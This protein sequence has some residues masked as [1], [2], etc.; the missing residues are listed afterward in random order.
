[1]TK[2][3]L[4]GGFMLNILIKPASS[5]CNMRCKYCFY[6]DV[7][8]NRESASF[9]IMSEAV[10]DAFLKNLFSYAKA[11]ISFTFQGGEPT[12]AGV[13]YFRAFHSLVEKYNTRGLPVAFSLQTNG[14]GLSEELV[15]VFAKYRY[16]L[17]V[18]LDGDGE[19]HDSLR[20][21]SDGA[22]T[23][24]KINES[25]KLLDKYKVEYNILTVITEQVASRGADVY[26]ILRERGF[27]FLQFIPF[28]PDFFGAGECESYTLTNES[29]AKFLNETFAEYHKDFISGNYVS[30]R[31]FDNFVRIAAGLAPECCGMGGSCVASIVVEA[32]GGVYPCDFYVLDR[33]KMGNV[34]TDTLESILSSLAASEFVK[35]S[36]F[37]L[38][39]CRECEFLPICRGGCRRHREDECGNLG[40]NRYCSAYK[41][42]FGESLP[43]IFDIAGRI[44]SN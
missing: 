41:S 44:K 21:A 33:W 5:L 11:P 42:F 32:D 15:L 14:Y 40:K 20:P 29:Y 43:L 27:K 17:G 12:L 39:E 18:S 3:T 28:V 19:L 6:R 7:A 23:Y 8:D 13:K 16:L 25:L 10:A 26:R 35:S 1:M 4:F 34:T 38:D 31:Q 22:P 36:M 30:V 24:E 2:N 9:G 37:I